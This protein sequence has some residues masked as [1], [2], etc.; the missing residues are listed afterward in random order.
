MQFPKR[1]HIVLH[2]S[3]TIKTYK[4]RDPIS[5]LHVFFCVSFLLLI[6][7]GLVT[8]QTLSWDHFF[9]YTNFLLSM[10]PWIIVQ[11][12][13]ARSL[14]VCHEASLHNPIQTKQ[15]QNGKH[16]YSIKTSLT[17]PFC[18][19]VNKIQETHTNT[20]LNFNNFS[21]RCIRIYL[22]IKEVYAELLI[23]SVKIW[24]SELLFCPKWIKAG[25]IFRWLRWAIQ[26]HY[27]PL[28]CICT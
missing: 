20:C 19:A 9:K 11:L 5:F 15:Q 10:L 26:Y 7:S 3:F 18:L 22:R 21:T 4:K 25:L 23:P 27:S 16:F 1:E 28:V 6:L 12:T 17:Y 8:K 13:W 2:W 14:S 24:I